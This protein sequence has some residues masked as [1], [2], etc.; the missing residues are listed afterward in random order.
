LYIAGIPGVDNGTPKETA[1]GFTNTNETLIVNAT[2]A[3]IVRPV[4]VIVEDANVSKVEIGQNAGGSSVPSTAPPSWTD[5]TKEDGDYITA[6]TKGKRWVGSMSGEPPGTKTGIY[7]R[8]TAQDGTTQVYRYVQHY[9]SSGGG[10]S[11]YRGEATSLSIGGVAIISSNAV[12]GTFSKG[13]FSGW[14]NK[15]VAP[16][17]EPGSV[18]I[19]ASAA[20]SGNVSLSTVFNNG[21]GQSLQ[22]AKVSKWP[23]LE[24]D[25]VTFSE[26]SN[27]MTLNNATVSGV[28]NGDYII[29]RMNSKEGVYRSFFTH[30][31][32]K[33]N[34]Q[35]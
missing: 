18:T 15:T 5:L 21:N 23:L 1:D 35:P 33:V 29:I 7:V 13:T 19:P 6:A 8:I 16:N 34:I 26:P 9:S 22:Y 25:I 30:Y 28:Q 27:G 32:I 24:T 31:I 2:L 14:W 10:T 11:A 3:G 17:F 12:Q 20:T 4:V